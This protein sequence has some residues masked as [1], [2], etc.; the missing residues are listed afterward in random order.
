MLASV[1]LVKLS[2]FFV[3][4]M[5]VVGWCDRSLA[6]PVVPGTGTKAAVI[7]DFE[8]PEW[9]YVPSDP[10]SSS[11]IDK[12]QRQPSG[13]SKNGMVYES[14]L[15]GQPD[16]I[17]R[18]ET[19]EGGLP[20][21][22]GALLMRSLKTGVPGYITNEMQQ[23]DLIMNARAKVGGYMST[24]WSPNTVVRV[25]VPPFDEWEQR[26]G[27]SFGFR[28]D[29]V[30]SKNGKS[31]AYWP[32]FFIQYFR[33]APP[34][35]PEPSAVILIRGNQLGHEVRGP[36]ITGPGWWTLGMSFTPDGMCH[37]Y[38]REGVENL[39]AENRLASYYCYGFHCDRF[40]SVFFNISNMDNGRSWST[41]WIVDDPQIF[42][43]RR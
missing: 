41:S 23:D 26:T 32:G 16:V 10:K 35:N 28:A 8:D 15:R 30:G 37:F 7:D 12:M 13:R 3:L 22:T 19:P 21:S 27:T 11:N 39:T 42:Y 25:Y 18:V 29:C 20:G 14:N 38:A 17:R 33:P 24:A 36:Q 40:N 9:A 5:A 6:A 1:E 34:R 2:Q 31:E 4:A 43:T